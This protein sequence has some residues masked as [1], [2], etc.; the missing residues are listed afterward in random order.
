MASQVQ[1]SEDGAAM[2][3]ATMES[4]LKRL[5]PFHHA[6]DLPYGL[7]THLPEFSRQEREKTR[8]KSL[9]DHAWPAILE[10]CGGTL[11]GKRVLDIACN[12]GGFAVAAAQAGAKQ[13][14]GIDVEDH[15]LEQANFI[16]DALALDNLEYR[17]L[18]LE[19]L[20]PETVGRFDLILCFGILYHLENP[21]LSL[22]RIAGV[23]DGALV[24]DTTLMRIPV[25]NNLLKRW[26][27]WHMKC[28]PAVDDTAWNITTSRW[29]KAE[30]LQFYPN[31]AA[32]IELMRYAGF[33]G[34][35]QLPATAKGLEPRYYSGGRATFIGSVR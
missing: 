32:V 13:V 7:S 16:R 35:R 6:I 2:P 15:Y 11:E 34:V 4:E 20:S 3:R 23:A 25:I 17:K 5:A 22:K 30:F 33:D 24:V 27:M 18:H 29:R 31:A 19:E 1:V 9:L 21:V 28:V 12:C 14:V 8:L 10:A 26:P